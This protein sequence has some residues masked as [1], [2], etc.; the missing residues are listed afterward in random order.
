M[1]IINEYHLLVG[2]RLKD[3]DRYRALGHRPVGGP[4]RDDILTREPGVLHHLQDDISADYIS[5]YNSDYTADY[6]DNASDYASDYTA[7][8]TPDYI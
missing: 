6:T 7:D 8:Y 1:V 3:R 5:H 4:R 2:L